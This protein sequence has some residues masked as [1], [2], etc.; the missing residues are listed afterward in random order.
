MKVAD[1][2][3]FALRKHHSYRLSL[4]GQVLQEEDINMSIIRMAV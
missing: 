1:V 3:G 2:S 4:I